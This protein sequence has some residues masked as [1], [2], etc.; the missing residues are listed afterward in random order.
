MTY[1]M[2][3]ACNPPSDPGRLGADLS[4]LG[5]AAVALYVVNHS[6]P[7]CVRDGGYVQ[8]CVNQGFGVCP[9]ITPGDFPPPGEDLVGALRGWG[10][11]GCP[12][13]LDIEQFSEPSPG[14]IDDE[15]GTLVGVGYY[16]GM[17]GPAAD[18]ARYSGDPWRWRW[19]ADWTFV[20]HEVPPYQAV[21]WTS[22]AIGPSGSNY[23]LSVVS[24]N[25]LMWGM[26]RF[27]VPVVPPMRTRPKG[28]DDM[29]QSGPLTGTFDGTGVNVLRLNGTDVDGNLSPEQPA[30]TWVYVKA[31]D[32][33]GFQG[34]LL[35]TL[36]SD[37]RPAV[38]VPILLSHGAQAKIV[39]PVPFEGGFSVVPR[40]GNE[41]RRYS[42]ACFRSPYA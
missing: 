19:L 27:G 38:A 13:A 24:D 16:P 9:L 39:A 15:I 3:D 1:R 29:W 28:G 30:V 20:E 36:L 26:P 2:A 31:I 17:Y 34:D 5:C 12:V 35:W 25:L 42:L 11:P 4:A 23:D 10:A 37:G 33:N 6:I 8:A 22:R 14:W 21:Q 18:H 40:P 7:G 32:A 41:T